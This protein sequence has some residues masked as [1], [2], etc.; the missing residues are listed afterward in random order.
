MTDTI[1]KIKEIE[2]KAE[3]IVKSA[4]EAAFHN[5]KAIHKR[6][7]AELAE[8][9]TAGLARKENLLQKA[10]SEAQEE[11]KTI[12]KE[13]QKEIVKIKTKV[14]NL[15]KKAKEEILRCLS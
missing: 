10:A 5:I 8:L 11:A 4:K 7:E 3:K 2:A 13:S 6:C 9:K 15:T 12:E 14:S 1:A